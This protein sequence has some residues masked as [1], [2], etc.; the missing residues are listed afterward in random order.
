M[1]IYN[2]LYLDS[3]G[4]VEK[5]CLLQKGEA[6]FPG[7]GAVAAEGDQGTRL[8]PRDTVDDVTS[9]LVRNLLDRGG[10]GRPPIVLGGGDR[11][12]GS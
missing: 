8:D 6:E 2:G 5:P 1:Y 12:T 9:R 7:D 11:R 3:K 4:L 10:R